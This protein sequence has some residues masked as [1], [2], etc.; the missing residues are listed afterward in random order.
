MYIHVIRILP[1]DRFRPPHGGSVVSGLADTVF[2]EARDVFDHVREHP[3]ILDYDVIPR[4]YVLDLP[5]CKSGKIGPDRFVSFMKASVGCSSFCSVFFR[6]SSVFSSSC[7]GVLQ[8]VVAVWF[9][10]VSSEVVMDA[11]STKEINLGAA[12][13]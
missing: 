4:T 1:Q 8:Y 5:A 9:A 6:K 7:V 2:V 10:T 13:K 12:R 3:G 11:V